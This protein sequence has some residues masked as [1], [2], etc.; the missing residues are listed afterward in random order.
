MAWHGCGTYFPHLPKISGC[1]DEEQMEVESRHEVVRR[2]PQHK[3]FF[4]PGFVTQNPEVMFG[5]Q[6]RPLNR[7]RIEAASSIRPQ[8]SAPAVVVVTVSVVFSCYPRCSILLSV[9]VVVFVVVTVSV[10]FQHRLRF[11]ISRFLFSCKN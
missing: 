10:V 9:V 8:R 11:I 7:A 3:L 6:R 4:T 5:D 1:S 2:S